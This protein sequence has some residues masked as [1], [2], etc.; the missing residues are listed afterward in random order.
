MKK[1]SVKTIAFI[2]VILIL[3]TLSS[4]SVEWIRGVSIGDIYGTFNLPPLAPPKWLFGPA[5]VLLYI[6]L[7]IYCANLNFVKNNRHALYTYM[8]VQLALN[9]FWTVVFFS[10]S[11]F[12][13]ATIMIVIMDLLVIAIIFVDK[14]RIKLLLVPYLLWLLFATYLSISVLILN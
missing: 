9:I 3:G 13:L 12:L 4:F 10:L 1:N 2:V 8:Y 6:L 7:G 14:R 11:N 5:W